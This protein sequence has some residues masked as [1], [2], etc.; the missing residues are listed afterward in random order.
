M[1]EVGIRG[2]GIVSAPKFDVIGWLLGRAVEG[3]QGWSEHYS[4]GLY[5]GKWRLSRSTQQREFQLKLDS[6][7]PDVLDRK[8]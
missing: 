2:V 8:L 3:R 4:L 5:Q 7:V 6:H 1:F